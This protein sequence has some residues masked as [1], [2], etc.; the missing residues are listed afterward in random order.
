MSRQKEV[1]TMGMTDLQFKSYV[2]KLLS[3]IEDASDD[4]TKEELLA[5]FMKLRRELTEDLTG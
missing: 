4:K 1:N 2:R 5:L 3:L